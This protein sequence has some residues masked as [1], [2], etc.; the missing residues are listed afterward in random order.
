MKKI[1]ALLLAL[2]LALSLFGCGQKADEPADDAPANN[3]PK[4]SDKVEDP[5]DEPEEEKKLI[6][7]SNAS[8]D[9]YGTLVWEICEAYI[10]EHGYDVTMTSAETSG[11]KQLS[12]I[13]DL[14]TLGCDLIYI[15]PWDPDAIV[16]AVEAC[17]EAG[18]PTVIADYAANTDK[19]NLYFSIDQTG[20]GVKQ[21]EY[22]ISL[23]EA[24]PDLQFNLCYLWGSFTFPPAQQR[25]DGLV[26][27]LQPYIDEGRV[28]ILDEQSIEMDGSKVMSKTED[29]IT[30]FPDAN[31]FIGANDDVAYGIS[32]TLKA[33]GYTINE[34]AW[35]L[36]IEGTEV[37]LTGIQEG[38]ISATVTFDLVTRSHDML[39]YVFQMLEGEDF[40]GET[41]TIEATG[42]VVTAE[43]VADYL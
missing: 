33:A 40:G 29:W 1:F 23:L 32:N 5:A 20:Y 17:V 31:C 3:D 30:R 19:A 35:V 27:T 42:I 21:G 38:A 22:L 41:M 39:D 7:F 13:E 10:L 25:R 16:P 2:I 43:N 9:E 36:G 6:G 24:D 37:G 18:I 15:R 12:D 28:V 14:I 8:S 26:N 4:P 11:E 34:D